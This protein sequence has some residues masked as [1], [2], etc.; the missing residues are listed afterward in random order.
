[1]TELIPGTALPIGD[2]NIQYE[3]SRTVAITPERA[4]VRMVESGADPLGI[5]DAN[6]AF[7]QAALRALDAE[8]RYVRTI[9]SESVDQTDATTGNV[10]VPMFECPQG[11]EATLSYAIFHSPIG[12]VTPVAPLANAAIFAFLA[13]GSP[14]N[15]ASNVTAFVNQL[16][17]GMIA[18][19]PQT[20]AAAGASFPAE[21]TFGDK[22]GP[23]LFGGQQL[24]AV[25]VGGSQATALNLHVHAAA[26]LTLRKVG[27]PLPGLPAAAVTMNQ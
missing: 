25:L 2:T 6:I 20:P 4:P 14:V 22:A 24:F 5:G 1:M 8:P 17:S 23:V 3:G 15:T 21:W 12:A 16:K 13:K 18:M 19:S 27:P 11:Y 7:I 10:V 9:W 26:R